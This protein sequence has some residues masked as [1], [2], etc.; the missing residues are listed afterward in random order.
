MGKGAVLVS[1]APS[2]RDHGNITDDD[3]VLRSPPG[4]LADSDFGGPVLRASQRFI[5]VQIGEIGADLKACSI[6]GRLSFG[7]LTYVVDTEER[8]RHLRTWSLVS[9]MQSF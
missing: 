2:D 8:D 3:L 1:C 5:A 4:G 7:A 6:G 9:S